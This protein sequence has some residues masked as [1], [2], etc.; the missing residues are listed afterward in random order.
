MIVAEKLLNLTERYLT[1]RRVKKYNHRQKQAKKHPIRDWIEA[2]LWAVMM[3]LFINQY[4]FQAYQIPSGSMIATLLEGDR[5]FVNKVIYGPELLPGLGKIASPIVPKRYDVM[6]FENPDYVTRGVVFS[7]V[8]RLLYMLTF[9]MVDIDRGA[10]N[11]ERHYLLIKRVIGV[12]GDRVRYIDGD[13]YIKP[14]GGQWQDEEQLKQRTSY[15]HQL[16]RLV[17]PTQLEE[18]RLGTR[19]MLIRQ[20]LD[21][22]RMGYP[23]SFANLGSESHPTRSRTEPFGPAY[24]L[25]TESYAINPQ[26]RVNRQSYGKYYSGWYLAANQIL[27]LGDNRDNSLDGRY[28]GPVKTEKVLGQAMFIYWPIPRLTVIR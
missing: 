27:P 24:D 3:V 13:F 14:Q 16:N 18:Q 28:F 21:E 26:N 1:Y 22:I 15:K 9:S 23:L 7:V 5:I 20:R 10:Q 11:E 12:E 17:M 19:N 6:C 2:F 8:Q 4:F 25:A